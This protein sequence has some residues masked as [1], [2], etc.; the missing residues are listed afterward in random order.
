MGCII[1]AEGIHPT[2][3]KIEAIKKAPRPE[4]V[5]QLRSFLGMV[6]YH[7]KFI[8]NLN[9]LNR[10]LQKG[11]EF[12][13]TP[14]CEKAFHMAKNS[15]SSAN[16]LV[17][18]DPKL[19]LILECDASP[20][21]IGAVLSHQFP[22]GV[23][24]PIAYASRSL[25][26]AEKNYSQIEKEGLAI[27][28]GLS[29]FYMY[30]YA[31]K[32]ILCTDHKP[33]LKI[34]APDS[35]TPVLAAA[36]LQRWSL[37][38]ASYHYEIRYKSSTEIANADALSRLPLKN[39]NDSSVEESIYNVADQQL[40]RHPVSAKQIARE[41]ARDKILSKVLT[42]TLYGWSQTCDEPELK[43]FFIRRHELSVEQGCLMWG[44]RVVIPSVFQQQVLKELHGTHPGVARMKAMA[45]SH[46][47]WPKIDSVIEETVCSCQQCSKNRTAPPA[48]PLHPWTWPSIPWQRI[49]I[50]FATY[51]GNH[52]LI[53]VDAHSKWPEVL[54]PMRTTNAEATINA[55]RTI[56]AR[57]GLPQ[58]IVSDN[59]P[60]FQSAE[61][62]DFLKQNGIQ[63][64]LVSPYHPSSNGQAERF[65]QTFK[66]FMKTLS[67]KTSLPQQIQNFLLSYRSTPHS[68]TSS[69]P[70]KLFLQREVRTRLSLVKP[71]TARLVAA[72]QS[73]MKAYH[74]QHAKLREF[75]CGQPVLARDHRSQGWQPATVLERKAPHSYTVVMPDGRIWNRH[76]DH[77]LQDKTDRREQTEPIPNHL[78]SQSQQPEV[79]PIPLPS[80]L[81]SPTV[82]SS[83]PLPATSTADES[84]IATQDKTPAVDASART[85]Q[86][87]SITEQMPRVRRSGRATKR[88]QRLIEQT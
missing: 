61:Y 9:P 53:V 4:N 38:L 26:N 58:Q 30:L 76:A 82:S 62:E 20:Y 37:L 50:D 15:L 81:S 8:P 87:P 70:S 86:R 35:A 22:D 11:Q 79:L 13:W 75:S 74:D 27:I 23:E 34:F 3:E 17:H 2:D 57:Y 45:R 73:K 12:K 40:N 78:G 42:F 88:P 10:L 60:P 16:V 32:F 29:K 83:I 64:V 19:P 48:A 41:T 80:T 51:Q 59:G 65:V 39:Q 28:F 55:L 47:W 5:T 84:D 1:S 71:D 44:L 49:H 24:R 6:N 46:V 33:L 21:G 67:S 43:P 25:N 77:L 72:N 14:E 56:F 52:Y 68:T 18:Y 7:G 31:R 69:T 36:R 54:G 63:R 85:E 66:K